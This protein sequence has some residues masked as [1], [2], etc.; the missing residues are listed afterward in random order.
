MVDQVQNK[1]LSRF[2]NKK[3]NTSSLPS[4]GITKL[5]NAKLQKKDSIIIGQ[6][7]RKPYLNVKGPRKMFKRP[8]STGGA[9]ITSERTTTSLPQAPKSDNETT[10]NNNP[11]T[12][13]Q[14]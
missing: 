10:K 2:T 9:S 14:L 12:L 7:P 11:L 8:P 13:Q 3:N 5:E 6:H 4:I 1:S